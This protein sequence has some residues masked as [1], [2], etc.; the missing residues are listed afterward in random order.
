MMNLDSQFSLQR[1]LVCGMHLFS[2]PREAG[3]EKPGSKDI[4]RGQLFTTTFASGL[5][6]R[7][8]EDR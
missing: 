1:F 8:A 4:F 5:K 2:W 3:A 6:R 7:D